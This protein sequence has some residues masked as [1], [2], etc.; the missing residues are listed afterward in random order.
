MYSC[1]RLNTE[2]MTKVQNMRLY[3]FDII[4][5]NTF[6]REEIKSVP[7]IC[8]IGCKIITAIFAAKFLSILLAEALLT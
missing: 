4:Y 8:E 3:Q 1:D 7:G 6:P 2:A 5:K